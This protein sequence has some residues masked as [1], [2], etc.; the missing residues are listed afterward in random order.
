[1]IF[2][3]LYD[4]FGITE[5]TIY[6]PAAEVGNQLCSIKFFSL[7]IIYLWDICNNIQVG[8]EFLPLGN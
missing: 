4:S 8:V 5:K 2:D 1:M 7:L 3:P 6:S